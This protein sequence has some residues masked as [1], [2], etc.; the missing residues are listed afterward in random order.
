M[1]SS[2]LLKMGVMGTGSI[3]S[4]FIAAA[5]SSTKVKVVAVGGRDEARSAA[6]AQR[7]G[8]A[9]H[10]GS[11]EALIADD[12]IDAVYIGLPN[13]LHAHWAI[14]AVEG[15]KHVLSEKPIDV[16]VAKAE[17]M[18][19]AGKANGKLVLEAYPYLAQQQT[20]NMFKSIRAG[21]I[22]IP[23]HIS[24]VFG[25]SVGDPQNI[26]FDPALGGGA[27]L[28]AGCYAIS[29]VQGVAGRLPRRVSAVSRLRNSV[30]INT[31][32]T[33]EFDGDL[34]AQ[35][36]CSLDTAFH[37]HAV[38]AG[39]KGVIQT[40]FLNHPPIGGPASFQIRRT[41]SFPT[42]DNPDMFETVPGEGGNGFLLEAESFADAIAFGMEYWTGATP[43]QSLQIMTIIEA[44]FESTRTGKSVEL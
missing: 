43:E 41:T 30:D 26:R 39:D 16:S 2:G 7:Y 37:R 14:K 29:L 28:D 10:Y 9:K 18:F 11:Y 12:E 21:E 34:T 4:Q 27:L 20:I 6:T 31:M 36:S 35:I 5:A 42:R 13:A 24:V 1:T 3:S 19:A 17:A 15:G 32:A 8:L 44:I 40:H 22:G 33:L 38:I 25:A 23:R